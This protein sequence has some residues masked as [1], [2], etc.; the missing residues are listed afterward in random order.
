MAKVVISGLVV[1]V[2][3]ILIGIQIGRNQ[4]IVQ[5]SV[6]M[7]QTASPTQMVLSPSVLPKENF[8]D[9]STTNWK[10]YENTVFGVIFS[11]PSNLNS[12]Q[13]RSSQAND[14]NKYNAIDL[15][16]QCFELS[17]A[18]HQS[19]KSLED[20][21]RYDFVKLE[22]DNEWE[23]YKINY[24]QLANNK[25]QV[26]GKETINVGSMGIGE[27]DNFFVKK[28]AS[29]ILLITSSVFVPEGMNQNDWNSHP[30]N[31]NA[32]NE[33]ETINRIISSFK[34]VN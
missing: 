3:A 24:L 34:F 20:Y 13:E 11:Y 1:I 17:I 32:S 33:N 28:D 25:T 21:I 15:S 27:T 29:T 23:N 5:Q 10:T 18:R 22:N 7:K 26:G 19:N 31:M 14:S 16:T 2:G 12:P 6:P 30:C 4:T 9:N 8:E